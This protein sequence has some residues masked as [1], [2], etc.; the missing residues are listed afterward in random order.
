[1][2]EMSDVASKLFSEFLIKRCRNYLKMLALIIDE[3]EK[4]RS[5]F[6]S[7]NGL[8]DDPVLVEKE[9][10]MINPWRQEDK[11]IFMEMFAKFGKNFSKISSFLMHKTTAD[12][13]EFYYKHHKSD[14]FREVKKVL[15]LRQQQPASNFLGAKSGKKW[16][17]EANAA[18]LDMLGVASVVATHG[19][20]YANRVE[21]ISAKS[22]IRTAYGS[23]VSFAA[24]KSSDRECIDNVPLHERE[25]VAADVLVGSGGSRRRCTY[26]ACGKKK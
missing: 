22:L 13:V 3:R 5:R 18:S 16:N 26:T 14:S 20:E 12:C 24:K 21:K 7:K 19:L 9:R 2:P 10:V 17:P 23:N 4:E 8:V 15:D 6:V 1:M 25:S 11:E